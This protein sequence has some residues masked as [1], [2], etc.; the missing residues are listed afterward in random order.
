MKLDGKRVLVTGGS[1]G[2]GLAMAKSLL[3]TAA[4]KADLARFGEALRREVKGEGIHV[5]TVYPGATD[6]PMMRT[7]R[8]RPEHGFGLEPVSAV[9]D[10]TIEG[11]EAGAFEVI[12]GGETRAHMIAR[13][14]DTPAIDDAPPRGSDER[15]LSPHT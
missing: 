3:T 11:I 2:I 9:A 5:L 10:A 14:R 7:N 13:E 8:S 12:R 4:A 15:S 1:S 6:T